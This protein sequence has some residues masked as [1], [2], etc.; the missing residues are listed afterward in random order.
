MKKEF[1]WSPRQPT[2]AAAVKEP[3]SWPLSFI[4]GSE[5]LMKTGTKVVEH[6]LLFYNER[7]GDEH[8]DL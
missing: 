6:K 1:S 4:R 5:I 3:D 7:R 2:A 8:D